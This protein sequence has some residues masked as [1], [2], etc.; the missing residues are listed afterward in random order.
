[1]I[2]KL[3][4]LHTANG[5]ERTLVADNANFAMQSSKSVHESS[6]YIK[7]YRGK[8]YVPRKAILKK[9]KSQ[10]QAIRIA[11]GTTLMTAIGFATDQRLEFTTAEA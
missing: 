2:Q 10:A 1:M 5:E 11:H 4:Q 3:I 8:K 7:M 6:N 9:C